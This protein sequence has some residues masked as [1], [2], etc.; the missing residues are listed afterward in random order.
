[1]LEGLTG[2]LV[3]AK[4][5]IVVIKESILNRINYKR[6]TLSISLSVSFSVSLAYLTFGKFPSGV[7]GGKYSYISLLNHESK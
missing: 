1:M 4:T 2:Y 7:F 6:E 3:G 5:Q